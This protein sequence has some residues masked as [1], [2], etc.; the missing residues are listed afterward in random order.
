MRSGLARGVSVV[1]IVALLA[2]CTPKG[3]KISGAGLGVSVVGAVLL[4]SA[5]ASEDGG[6]SVDARG[7]T[8]VL[9]MLGGGMVTMLGMAVG[10]E[11]FVRGPDAPPPAPIDPLADARRQ[12]RDRAW[13][14]TKTAAA[15][16][17]AGD[18]AQVATL[19]VEIG[20]LDLE[21][22]HT[23]FA[24]DAAIARCLRAPP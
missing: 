2:G 8:G 6:P 17:R 15:A 5:V 20:R 12:A 18:C 1:A 3:L 16:A 10:L 24:R 4:T 13:Q 7:F 14:L 23:V 19:D 22:H 9:L 21:F 11:G